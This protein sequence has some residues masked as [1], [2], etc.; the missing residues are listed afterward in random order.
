[1]F[2]HGVT[3][4]GSDGCFHHEHEQEW[5]VRVFVRHCGSEDHVEAGQCTV[6]LSR[7]G[8]PQQDLVGA[9]RKG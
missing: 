8:N 2:S 7:S 5:N 1:M 4:A 9:R 3:R 6:G